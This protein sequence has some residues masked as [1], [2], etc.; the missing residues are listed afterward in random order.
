MEI[1]HLRYFLAVAEELHFTR[2]ASLLHV[3]QPALSHQIRQLEEEVGVQ[4]LER[5]KRRV[6]L[7]P[8]GEVFR[9]RA[10]VV[11]E[12]AA[13]AASDAVKVGRGSAG[14]V[15]IGVGSTAIWSVLPELVMRF[16][17]IARAATVDIREMEPSD[18]LEALRHESIDVGIMA[19]KPRDPELESILI[20][21]EKLIA[22]LPAR[23]PMAHRRRIDLKL[24]AADTLILPGRLGMPGFNE[25]V[26]GAFERV[27][28][29][30]VE[31]LTTRQI[32][33]V[34]CLVAGRLG[35]ALVPESFGRNMQVKGVVYRPIT[36]P[37]P[38]A[39]LNAVW[40]RNN[41]LPLV[42][43][44]QNELRLLAERRLRRGAAAEQTRV[45]E[46]Y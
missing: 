24:L 9:N 39:E 20:L 14:S 26:L 42:T 2:A 31:T 25:I 36:E 29:I 38:M 23:H 40:R 27:G 10:R 30:P 4:L 16:R 41:K 18:Q 1:R 45:D 32:Q 6:K 7:T 17:Q 33:T 12:Q 15:A 3:A 22:V 19:A 13:R 28:H 11:V 34:I 46:I 35:V 43:R 44:F 21:R 37:A 8:A 5:T